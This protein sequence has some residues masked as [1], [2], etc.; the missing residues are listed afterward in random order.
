MTKKNKRII[1][2]VLIL[3]FITVIGLII[4]CNFN[5]EKSVEEQLDEAIRTIFEWHV[6]REKPLYRKQ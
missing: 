4:Y 1:S 3:F 2:V 5:P 6:F